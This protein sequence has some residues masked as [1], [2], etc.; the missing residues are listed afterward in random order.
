MGRDELK[1]RI[2]ALNKAPLKNEPEPAS[3][4]HSDIKALRRKL[5]KQVSRPNEPAAP[6]HVSPPDQPESIVYSRSIPA[7]AARKPAPQPHSPTRDFG[8]PVKLEEAIEGVV[9][10]APAGPGYYLVEKPA[11]ELEAAASLVHRRFISLTGH[12]DGEAVAR[13]AAVCR[14]SRI[15]PEEV[16]FLDLETTGLGMTPVFLVGTMECLGDGFLFRQYFARDYS[17]EVSIVAAIAERILSA[18]MLVTFNGKTFDVPFLRN[19][20]VATGIRL[21]DPASHLDLLYESRRRY[22]KELPNCRLQ[23]LEHMICGRRREDDIPGAEIPAA[24]HE[25][26]RTGNANKIQL[27]L[28]HNLYDLLTM[29]DLMNR[30]WCDE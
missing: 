20:S 27:I 11:T 1:R 8:P 22:R 29:A 3:E 10:D 18:R 14:A 25:Y 24:Y 12:P 17:E 23:T 5:G 21:P 7:P 2:E 19:R 6:Q 28:M 16:L 9:T 4:E 26:V 13:I 15:A 30:L